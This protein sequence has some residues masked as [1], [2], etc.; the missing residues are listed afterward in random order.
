MTREIEIYYVNDVFEDEK[1]IVAFRMGDLCAFREDLFLPKICQ[2]ESLKKLAKVKS[3]TFTYNSPL[4][5]REFFEEFI[6]K[7]KKYI[8]IFSETEFLEKI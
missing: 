6:E 7:F 2:E 4:P 5:K 1:Y 8:E 3:K